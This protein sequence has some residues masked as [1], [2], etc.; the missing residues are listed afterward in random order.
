MVKVIGFSNRQVGTPESLTTFKSSSGLF[1]FEI[2]TR[3]M[4]FVTFS[5]LLIPVFTKNDNIGPMVVNNAME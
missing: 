3:E 1:A 2:T 5:S 4:F